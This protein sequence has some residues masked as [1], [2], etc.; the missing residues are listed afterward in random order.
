M[1]FWTPTPRQKVF[2][3]RG[4]WEALFGGAAGPGKTDALVMMAARN[5]GN[6]NYHGLILRRTF[7]QMQEIIDRTRTYYPIIDDSARYSEKDHRWYFSTGA[8]INLGHMQHE[9]DKFSYHGHEYGGIFFDELTQFTEGQ[10]LYMFSRCRST[11]PTIRPMVR[12]TSNPGNVGHEWVKNRFVTITEPGKT[13]VDP[14]TG[15][16]R[17]FIPAK[18]ADN[19]YLVENDPDYIQRLMLLP[20]N[21]RL[22][23]LEGI[24]DTFEGQVFAELNTEIHKIDPF[25]IPPEWKRYRC[26][27]WGY[28]SPFTVQ[29]FA[30]DYDGRLYLYRE[31]YGAQKDE[32]KRKHV[33]LKMNASEIA[34]GI[35]EREREEK[36]KGIKVAPGPADPAIWSKRRDAKSGVVGPSVADE[37][38]SEGITW[39][40]ADNDRILGKQ[41]FHTRLA[42]DEN[43]H[44]NIYIFSDCE[45][46]WRTLPM[47]REDPSNPEDVDH[48]DAEDHDYDCTRYMCMFRPMRPRVKPRSEV[49]T[50]AHERN[51]YIK[52]KRYALSRGVSISQA[53]GMVR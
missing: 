27:D 2:M 6:S 4:E 50:F 7:P 5:V 33:G 53:Y 1:G 49:G 37:M 26:F 25:D 30:V 24:W 22:R 14:T 45:H 28:S 35:F 16:S 29:W 48:E 23:Y 8:T 18:L 31:W 38:M 52:A 12:C 43:G 34:R 20:P 46:W 51:K 3:K 40:K 11:D 13:Y 17:C 44:P 36:E 21:D 39:L 42:L 32:I 19:P 15:L 10:Y 9:S 41:Q 47:L